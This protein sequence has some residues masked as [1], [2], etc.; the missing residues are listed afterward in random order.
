MQPHATFLSSG[1]DSVSP[2]Q[3]HAHAAQVRAAGLR[4]R[5]CFFRELVR[6]LGESCHAP[7]GGAA[8]V[9]SDVDYGLVDLL[10]EIEDS[11]GD[12]WGAAKGGGDVD[13]AEN[14]DAAAEAGPGKGDVSPRGRL[15]W[16]CVRVLC[17]DVGVC[18]C[19]GECKHDSLAC[20]RSVRV[21][22]GAGEAGASAP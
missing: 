15:D 20:M 9:L 12:V 7:G 21:C 13:M 6:G 22:L 18:E 19:L 5:L 10:A 2:S 3:T 17:A 8:G 4:E 14:G 1:S 11:E 16:V